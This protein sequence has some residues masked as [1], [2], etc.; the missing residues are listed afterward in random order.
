MHPFVKYHS[1]A[2][3]GHATAAEL[4]KANTLVETL[5]NGT[6]TKGSLVSAA[7]TGSLVITAGI[8]AVLVI[9]TLTSIV[10]IRKTL[11][12]ELAYAA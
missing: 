5:S 2:S 9:L 1:K 10:S 7:T 12:K 11:K 8:T 6:L 4:A 3:L